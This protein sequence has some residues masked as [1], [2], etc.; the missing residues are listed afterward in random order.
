MLFTGETAVTTRP[1]DAWSPN[2]GSPDTGPTNTRPIV[3]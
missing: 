3:A 2:R 1:T